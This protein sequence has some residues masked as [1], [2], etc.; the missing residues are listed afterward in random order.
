LKDSR[1]GEGEVFLGRALLR[2]FPRFVSFQ[3]F[4]ARKISLSIL[5]RSLRQPNMRDMLGFAVPRNW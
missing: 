2:F 3:S 1:C 4:A 5:R